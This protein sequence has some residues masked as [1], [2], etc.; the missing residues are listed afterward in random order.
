MLKLTKICDS[1]VCVRNTKLENCI[2]ILICPRN[3]KFFSCNIC[4]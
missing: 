4:E 3:S 2:N 1:K